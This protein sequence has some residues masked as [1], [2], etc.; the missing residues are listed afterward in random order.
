MLLYLS[1]PDVALRLG[2]SRQR[3]HQL[4]VA[5]ILVP[6][7]QL[8][9]NRPGARPAWGYLPSTIDAFAEARRG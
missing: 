2:I 6:D 8:G 3:V 9:E 4:M 1:G 5:G 7:L